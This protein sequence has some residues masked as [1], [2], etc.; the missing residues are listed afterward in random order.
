MAVMTG[1]VAPRQ[2]TALHVVPVQRDRRARR[3]VT[4]VRISSDT[5]IA[6]AMLVP[7]RP[8]G[9]SIAALLPIQRDRRARRV[10]RGS[11]GRWGTIAFAFGVSLLTWVA[12]IAAT[13]IIARSA[14]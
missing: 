9:P 10:A 7:G 5:P 3:P 14:G 13:M 1:P 4:V 11:A 2:V 8:G 6:A 12:I